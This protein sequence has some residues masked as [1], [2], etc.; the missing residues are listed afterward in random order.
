M[1]RIEALGLKYHET[2]SI[3]GTEKPKQTMYNLHPHPAVIKLV[4]DPNPRQVCI[5]CAKRELGSKNLKE[6]NELEETG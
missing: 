6:F 1:K 5:K 4:V 3:C 2:C